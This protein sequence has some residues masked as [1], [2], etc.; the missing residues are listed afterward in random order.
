MHSNAVISD[1][2]I[3]KSSNGYSLEDFESEVV[4]GGALG[5]SNFSRFTIGDY[6]FK[7]ALVKA[8]LSTL[9]ASA[10]PMLRG[11]R[12]IV[13]VPDIHDRGSAAISGRTTVSFNRNFNV[14][15]EV[16]LTL[17][18]GVGRPPSI[19]L[20]SVEKGHF[21]IELVADDGSLVDGEISWIA[22][23]Y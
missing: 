20:V 2:S 15:P 8:E 12:L 21:L 7:D 23:G 1:L 3:D 5:F 22:Q 16:S 18:S 4:N 11:I 19:N 13:D 14:K 9:D 6:R 17:K 10:S